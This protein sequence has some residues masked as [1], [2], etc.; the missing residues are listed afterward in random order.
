MQSPMPLDDRTNQTNS[1]APPA[2]AA[3]TSGAS[4]Y[5]SSV[6]HSAQPPSQPFHHAP[7]VT[8]PSF[9]PPTSQ[10][11]N[12]IHLA[13]HTLI[14]RMP[15][16]HPAT[17]SNSSWDEL[18]REM[19]HL[20]NPATSAAFISGRY[21]PYPPQQPRPLYSLD[22]SEELARYWVFPS[23]EAKGLREYQYRIARSCLFGNTLVVL[24]TVR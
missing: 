1:N 6:H 14:P 13:P 3:M 23:S 17:C 2:L 20:P 8:S 18:Q 10:P 24:P 9:H 4:H 21:D 11:P 15:P 7:L 22:R 16:T 12:P 19:I 5:K